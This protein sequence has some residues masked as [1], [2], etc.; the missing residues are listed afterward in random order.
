MSTDIDALL[1]NPMGTSDEALA[2]MMAEAHGE[3]AN[4][5]TDDASGAE[6]MDGGDTVQAT[7]TA[8][9]PAQQPQGEPTPQ[10][11]A[12]PSNATVLTRDGKH[13]IPYSVLES[14][15]QRANRA[16]Q[17]ALA[18]Q[19]LAQQE[20]SQ[21][22]LIERQLAELT[23]R[24]NAP[25]DAPKDGGK[26]VED[27]ISGDAIEAIREEAP[28]LAAMFDQLVTKVR[29]LDA[30]ARASREAAERSQRELQEDR[31]RRAAEK[32]NEA[33]GNN[34]KLVYTRA[35]K[36]EV[37]N[38]IVEVDDWVRQQGWARD[39]TLDQRFAK[40]V[41]MYEAAHGQIDV[42]GHAKPEAPKQVSDAA[43][44]AIAKASAAPVP[45]T[46]SDLPGGNLPPK[47]EAEAFGSLDAATMQARLMEMDPA[48]IDKLLAR[49]P[50]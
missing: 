39:M 19:Q 16:A 24:A 14:E 43:A 36:P 31:S 40:S 45:N 5:T 38:A 11:E 1:R 50:L 28:E 15:R 10:G 35:E 17:E 26:P 21:R 20:R 12:E 9:E 46:L 44:A 47:S 2:K 30:D 27:I 22:E 4:E 18:A 33:I 48:Q 42:P 25:T 49:M 13:Q 7:Q 29:S 32:V 37:F 34:P 6:P 23:A 41:A 3:E 8:D